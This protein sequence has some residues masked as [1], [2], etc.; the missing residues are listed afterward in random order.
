MKGECNV[1]LIYYSIK[2]CLNENVFVN[3]NENN[4][5]DLW[6]ST[7]KNIEIQREVT[8]NI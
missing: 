4:A 7:M 6:V 2:C 1:Y 8:F 5:P 3:K